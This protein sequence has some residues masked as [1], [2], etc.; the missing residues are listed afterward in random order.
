MGKVTAVDLEKQ[1][2]GFRL[3]R[4]AFPAVRKAFAELSHGF[5]GA[6]EYLTAHRVRVVEALRLN[7]LERNVQMTGPSPEPRSTGSPE[8][9]A[10]RAAAWPIQARRAGLRLKQSALRGRESTTRHGV[11]ARTRGDPYMSFHE[12]Q[13]PLADGFPLTGR[14]HDNRKAGAGGV[15]N[16]DRKIA[17]ISPKWQRRALLAGGAVA[18]VAWVKGA[19]H[20]PSFFGEDL[21]FQ[22]INGLEP[23][24]W[25]VGT[26]PPTSI[27]GSI[28]VGIDSPEP[29]TPEEERMLQAV[30][31]DPCAAFFGPRQTGPVPVAMF[32]DFKCPVCKV[33]NNRLADLQAEAPDSFRIVR[34]ELPLLGAASRTASRAVLAADRQGAYLEMHDR[35]S[36]TPAVTDEVFVETIADA[37]GLDGDRLLRD[38]NSEEI[39]QELRKSRAIADVFGFHGTPAFAVGRTV[40]LGSISKSSLERLISQET[41]NPV[42]PDVSPRR[43]RQPSPRRP[44]RPARCHAASC[45][46][47]A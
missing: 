30:R 34:H 41:G 21:E 10:C 37:M 2:D 14:L 15:R 28:L 46:R 29:L 45:A 4:L 17:E 39:E 44:S 5:T 19:P 24:R 3:Q 35:L 42:E 7:I 25:L 6:H 1:P 16:M 32:S 47:T 33:M 20:L 9:A 36:R 22:S 27:S 18:L 8:G 13:I 26:G 31:D 38:M 40:F 23:F 43:A 11:V 12:P